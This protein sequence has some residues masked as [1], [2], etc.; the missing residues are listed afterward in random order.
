MRDCGPVEKEVRR[1]EHK[2]NESTGISNHHAAVAGFFRGSVAL[3][4]ALTDF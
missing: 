3:R 4:M 1:L 2:H